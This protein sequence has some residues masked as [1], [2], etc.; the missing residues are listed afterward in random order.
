[1]DALAASPT[2]PCWLWAR[3]V[4]APSRDPAVKTPSAEIDPPEALQVTGPSSG[5]PVRSNS[6]ARNVIDSPGRIWALGGTTTMSANWVTVSVGCGAWGVEEVPQPIATR[7]QIKMY[8]EDFNETPPPGVLILRALP[9][10][11]SSVRAAQRAFQF[12]D[13]KRRTEDGF[14]GSSGCNTIL[15]ARF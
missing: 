11:R 6:S 15:F 2:L 3:T 9:Y 14:S 4:N 1:M 13:E 10:R 5:A 12:S 8:S 7:V